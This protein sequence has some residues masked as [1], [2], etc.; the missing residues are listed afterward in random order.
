MGAAILTSRKAATVIACWRLQAPAGGRQQARDDEHHAFRAPAG[1]CA[2]E[3][4]SGHE[5]ARE[6]KAQAAKVPGSKL[7]KVL[8]AD[9]PQGVNWPGSK[10]AVNPHYLHYFTCLPVLYILHLHSIM[11]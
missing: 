10:K 9:S 8:L 2:T 1:A 7:A 6:Q 5:R 11:F 3:R 4:A